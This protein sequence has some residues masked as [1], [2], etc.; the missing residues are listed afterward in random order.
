IFAEGNV[1][2]DLL[3]NFSPPV[4]DVLSQAHTSHQFFHQS[5]KA[6]A[7]QFTI[8]LRDAK[9][10]VQACP[11]CQQLPGPLQGV[12]PRGLTSLQLWQTDVTHVPEFGQLKYVHVSVDT[13]SHAIWATS[14]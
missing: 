7:K 6:L 2:A 8:P 14:L 12:N 11:D 1:Q 3:T 5:A 9:L 10:I 4:P 13:Y